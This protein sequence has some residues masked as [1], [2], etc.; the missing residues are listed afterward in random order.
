[1]LLKYVTPDKFCQFWNY[2]ILECCFPWQ[3]L[4][5]FE[6]ILFLSIV[7]PERLHYTCFYLHIPNLTVFSQYY[8]SQCFFLYHLV[9]EFCLVPTNSD[10]QTHISL[11]PKVVELRFFKLWILLDQIVRFPISGNKDIEIRNLSYFKSKL[12]R[13]GLIRTPLNMRLRIT[14]FS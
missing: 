10:F 1:M 11:Q 3:N 5:S 6:T 13:K 14:L 8:A 2:F 9:K 7:S 12:Q 4:V